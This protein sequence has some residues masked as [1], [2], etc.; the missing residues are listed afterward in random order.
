MVVVE[1]QGWIWGRGRYEAEDRYAK[2]SLGWLGK[3]EEFVTI[4]ELERFGV[5]LFKEDREGDRHFGQT[6]KAGVYRTRVRV[7]VAVYEKD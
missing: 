4:V 1:V 2:V 7:N 6:E 5:L 3:L